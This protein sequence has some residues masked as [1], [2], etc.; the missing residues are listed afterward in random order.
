MGGFTILSGIVLGLFLPD[1]FKKPHPTFLPKWQMFTDREIYIL[2]SRVH[3]DEPAKS[4]KKKR[5]GLAAFKKAVR[6]TRSI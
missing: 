1:S 4:R 6:F 2:R 5:I 3:I